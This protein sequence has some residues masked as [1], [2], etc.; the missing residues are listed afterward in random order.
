M[1]P[2]VL[3]SHEIV[4]GIEGGIP[5]ISGFVLTSVKE[6][7]LVEVILR[8]PLPVTE[9]N[10]TVLA[11]WTY[12][13]GKTVALTTD[14]GNRWADRWTQWEYYDKLFSQMVRWA[15]RPTGDQGN[16]SVATS[17][18]EGKTQVIITALDSED[19]F[20]NDQIMS[21][22]VVAPDM[23][24]STLRIEQTAP[25]RYVGE[26]PSDQ[27]GSYLVVVNPG[28]DRAPIRTGVSVG[29]SAE[30]RDFSTNMA[31]L[32]S[33]AQMSV[34]DGPAG[35]LVE[36][37]LDTQDKDQ[38]TAA[39]PFRRDLKP[40]RSNQSIWP[41]LVLAG[42]CIFFAD[43]FVRRVQ[44]SFE[45]LTPLL[46]KAG[47]IVLRRER[48]APAPETMSRLRTRKQEVSEQIE[49]RRA[50]TRFEPEQEPES[51]S[52]VAATKSV[53][54]PSKSPKSPPPTETPDDSDEPSYTERLL[55][56]KRQVW[57]DR[58]KDNKK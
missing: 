28:T 39:N 21:G 23:S 36:G 32:Q 9:K 53:A 35:Q 13:A 37:G 27:P 14:A 29:Y 58:D 42:S 3:T 52:D 40:A 5:S 43:V 10:A 34:K 31:L 1:Q 57:D 49:D 48:A 30:Y 33:I 55:K 20:L 24:S 19:E 15:M 12:G 11:A 50:A 17:S 45:W 51:S 16:F 56:A 8:S 7:P 6:N 22:T 38:L 47:D 44:I 54:V 2:S 4:S 18:S 41:W 25:G 46:A 26:F